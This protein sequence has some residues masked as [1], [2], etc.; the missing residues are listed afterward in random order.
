MNTGLVAKTTGRRLTGGVVALLAALAVGLLAGCGSSKPVTGS[1]SAKSVTLG[2]QAGQ[3]VNY[4]FPFMSSQYVNKTNLQPFQ[5]LMYRPLYWWD[6]SPY[7][8]N[9]ARSLA[10]KPVFRD[11]NR[12]I[13]IQMKSGWRFS[14]GEK[15]GPANVALFLN[16]LIAQRDKFWM[17]LPGAFPDTL[18]STSY[19]DK[20]N[21]VTLHLKNPVNPTW[22]L[23]NQLT[24]IT[25]LPTAWDLSAAGKKANCESENAAVAA[26]ACSAVYAYMTK[27]SMNTQSYASNPLWQIV[28]GPFR[29]SKFESGGTSVTLVPNKQYSGSPK[30]SISKL[31]LSV[32]TS[33]AAEYSLLKSHALTIGYVPYAS[34]PIKSANA[35]TPSVNPVPGYTFQPVTATWSYNDLFW[36]Y[37]NPQLGP[38]LH[39]LYFRQAM[40]SLMDQQGDIQAALRGYGYENYGPNPPQPDNPYHTAYQKTEP[41]QFSIAKA[42]SYLTEHGWSVPVSGV[43]TCIRAGSAATQCGA[44]IAQGAKMPSIKLQY[45]TGDSAWALE[46]TNL[47]SDASKAGIKI[48]PVATPEANLAQYFAGCTAKQAT[49]KWQMIYLGAPETDTGTFYPETGVVF[50]THAIF[51]VSN[52]S[53]PYV[54]SLF[55]KIYTQ[56]GD[57]ALNTLDDYL[58]KT[59]ALMWAPVPDGQLYETEAGLQG[60]TPSPIDV[61]E[62]EDWTFSR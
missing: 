13:V 15:I 22:F 20:A 44:G 38:L 5:D 8:L 27:Q 61:F 48:T 37:N 41:Y 43:A 36:N 56:S 30:P 60:F 42:K 50:R 31:V 32:A 4:I 46:M 26:K 33:D 54:E 45:A 6:G 62:P 7:V 9:V 29:L 18:K 17:Y 39:Q 16:M 1:S 47:Q 24:M 3:P 59:A 21:T 10:E 25:P 58:T 2:L 12:T 23:Q 19:D 52:Y 55:D 53:N 49:C 11:G 51:N 34:A 40:Q 28:D 57:D 35:S 14:N